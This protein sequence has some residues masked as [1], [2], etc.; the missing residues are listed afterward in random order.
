MVVS[1]DIWRECVERHNE[2]PTKCAGEVSS[3]YEKECTEEYS[4]S[5]YWYACEK[6][7][8]VGVVAGFV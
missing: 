8:E 1:E 5:N 4:N 7:D 6:G 2:K 3:P